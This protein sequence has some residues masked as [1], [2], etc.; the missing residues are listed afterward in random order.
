MKATESESNTSDSQSLSLNCHG[1]ALCHVA[2]LLCVRQQ[3]YDRYQQPSVLRQKKKKTL[4]MSVILPFCLSAVGTFYCLKELPHP[5][6][7]KAPSYAI[8]LFNYI[9][10]VTMKHLGHPSDTLLQSFGECVA[11]LGQCMQV[12]RESTRTSRCY[13]D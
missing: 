4:T 7:S 1:L 12:R 3:V 13:F 9:P 2:T 8:R 6:H 5:L 10:G 11:D